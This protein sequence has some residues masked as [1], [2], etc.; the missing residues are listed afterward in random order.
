VLSAAIEFQQA[1]A[2][3]QRIAADASV[4]L[5]HPSVSKRGC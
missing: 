5:M 1:V 3:V 2:E 4:V